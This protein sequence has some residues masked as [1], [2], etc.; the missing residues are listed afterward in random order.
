MSTEKITSIVKKTIK[1]KDVKKEIAK[2]YIEMSR[3]PASLPHIKMPKHEVEA[4]ISKTVKI[5]PYREKVT[6]KMLKF[7]PKGSKI[8][9]TYVDSIIDQENPQKDYIKDIVLVETTLPSGRRTAFK[10]S[11]D[12]ETGRIQRSWGMSTYRHRLK[13]KM[14]PAE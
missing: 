2:N 11:I 9:V 5:L 7:L 12:P 14:N 10:A 3:K 8:D 13:F 1:K 6:Q 4:K